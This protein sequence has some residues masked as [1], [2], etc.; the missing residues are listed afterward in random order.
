VI[1][2]DVLPFHTVPVATSKEG[3]DISLRP[4]RPANL[5]ETIATLL[6][7]RVSEEGWSNSER[8]LES[9]IVPMDTMRTG[10]RHSQLLSHHGTRRTRRFT[11]TVTPTPTK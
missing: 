6:Y 2:D 7:I 9:S 8:L 1:E 10:Q 5:A 11:P 3:V 4:F